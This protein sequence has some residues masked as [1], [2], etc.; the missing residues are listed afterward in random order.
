MELRMRSAVS[1]NAKGY[2]IEATLDIGGAVAE[3]A[4]SPLKP[5]IQPEMADELV[6]AL[7]AFQIAKLQEH[8]AKL[9]EAFPREDA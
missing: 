5:L 2:S 7:S 1:R 6:A 8:M 4:P 9:G 3:T